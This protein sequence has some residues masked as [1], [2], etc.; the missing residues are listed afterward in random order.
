M[1]HPITANTQTR[2]QVRSSFK[3]VKWL[4]W[5]RTDFVLGI[6]S[7]QMLVMKLHLG[8][9]KVETRAVSSAS[10]LSWSGSLLK[11]CKN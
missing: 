3:E 7:S 8:P 5:Y 4:I 10:V 2:V 6:T 9:F 1:Q 11:R